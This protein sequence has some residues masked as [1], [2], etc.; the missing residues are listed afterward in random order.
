M[1]DYIE[2]CTACG[3]KMQCSCVASWS[4]EGFT[5]R[6]FVIC[7]ICGFGPTEAFACKDSAISAWNHEV[8]EEL[9]ELT[10]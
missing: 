3:S 1:K 5:D 10:D 7:T 2:P 8:L 9:A 4:S 6:Y